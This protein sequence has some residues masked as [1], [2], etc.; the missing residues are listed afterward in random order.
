[1]RCRKSRL[2]RK[3][4]RGREPDSGAPRFYVVVVAFLYRRRF[5]LTRGRT[6][7]ANGRP[8]I[9]V[10]ADIEKVQCAHGCGSARFHTEL[11]IN[12]LEMLLHGAAAQL[13]DNADLR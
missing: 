5:S 6:I 10:V 1:M 12:V 3:N 8:S 9:S 13:K 7:R 4:P 11:A 2:S